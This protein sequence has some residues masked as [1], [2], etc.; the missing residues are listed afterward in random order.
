MPG[1]ETMDWEVAI[2]LSEIIGCVAVVI[3]LLFLS[4]DLRQNTRA[5]QAANYIKVNDTMIENTV[6]LTGDQ[7]GGP[8]FLKAMN[9]LAG[10][11]LQDYYHFH[12]VAL[13]MLRR[14][15]TL[16]VQEAMGLMDGW[17]TAGFTNSLVGLLSHRGIQEW[18][19]GSDQ[20]FSPDFS[21]YVTRQM[22]L[23]KAGANG[24]GSVHW[25]DEGHASNADAAGAGATA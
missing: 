13:G 7:A 19:A 20:L 17:S 6:V 21:R 12:L 23:S 8:I 10:L 14:Y 4:H 3:S 25:N 9:G 15:E 24:H 11:D 22:E 1:I 5:M 16:F 2:A 18:W